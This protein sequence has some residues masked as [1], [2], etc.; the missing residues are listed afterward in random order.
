MLV[1]SVNQ[2]RVFYQ[3]GWPSA[4]LTHAAATAKGDRAGTVTTANKSPPAAA[5]QTAVK[6]DDSERVPR[7]CSGFQFLADHPK[8]GLETEETWAVGLSRRARRIWLGFHE[9]LAGGKPKAA[10][11]A[12][13]NSALSHGCARLV[14]GYAEE[15]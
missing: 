9:L 10:A 1:E 14:R 13:T 5:H 15:R 6:I 2:L 12:E 8:F 4:A 3:C 11:A 7:R